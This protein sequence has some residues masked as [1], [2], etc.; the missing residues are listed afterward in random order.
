MK[1][2]TFI[3]I[4]YARFDVSRFDVSISFRPPPEIIEISASCRGCGKK[5]I[6]IENTESVHFLSKWTEGWSP[7]I[8]RRIEEEIKKDL[9]ECWRIAKRYNRQLKKDLEIVPQ[10]VEYRMI[11]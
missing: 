2:S 11:R 3:Q 6:S 1:V 10:S 4:L 9:C 8:V 5:V 7:L